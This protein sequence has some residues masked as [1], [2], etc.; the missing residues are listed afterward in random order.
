[1]PKGRIISLFV[2]RISFNLCLTFLYDFFI[3]LTVVV[4]QNK[5]WI[6]LWR[7]KR[8]GVIGTFIVQTIPKYKVGKNLTWICIQIWFH[9]NCTVYFL[10]NNIGNSSARLFRNGN[11]CRWVL[12]N[13]NENSKRYLPL[14][15]KIFF[16]LTGLMSHG[17]FCG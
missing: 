6:L 4:C 8:S 2:L 5:S 10:E 14:C 12:K 13:I 16:G 17:Q 1:M 9:L 3:R 15:D 7:R 11:F